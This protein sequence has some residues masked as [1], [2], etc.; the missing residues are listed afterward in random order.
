MEAHV[1]PRNRVVLT[2]NWDAVSYV[3]FCQLNQ[4]ILALESAPIRLK[5]AAVSARTAAL[6]KFAPVLLL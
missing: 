4:P 3:L 5:T 1:R 2:R 6:T